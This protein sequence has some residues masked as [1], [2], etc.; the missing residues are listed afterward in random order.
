[1]AEIKFESPG[2][3]AEAIPPI[4]LQN[5][6]KQIRAAFV[7]WHDLLREGAV[8]EGKIFRLPQERVS[9]RQLR[10]DPL[11]LRLEFWVNHSEH[12]AVQINEPRSSGSENPLSGIGVGEDGR[13]FL[14]RQADLQKNKASDRIRGTEFAQRTCIPI[15]PVMVNGSPAKRQW[16]I[17]TPLDGLSA[18]AIRD[19]T[20]DFVDRCWTARSWGSAVADDQQR[21]AT[22]FASGET[23]GWYFFTPDPT[24]RAV[25]RAQGEVWQELD[26]V[27]AS[28][29]IKIQK[30]RP[31]RRYEV[32]AEILAAGGA[33]LV[34]IKT[35]ITPADIYGGIGQLMV[36][37][38]LLQGLSKHARILL[39]PGR[40]P[41]ALAGAVR[42]CGI[43]LH[44]FRIERQLQTTRVRFSKDFLSRCG[45]PS[46]AIER[47]GAS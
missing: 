35:G 34:E 25:L 2:A 20:A 39:L 32:D 4:R 38:I 8:Q 21:L 23:G 47:L 22:L 9:F 33:L 43:E 40:P 30:P 1:M 11:H 46:D 29:S 13:R 10:S 19:A 6:A 36:Y 45:I 15:A 24:P 14:L 7:A 18:G 37:P 27:L 16:H 3:P 28:Y 5:N 26:R 42:E 17:V 12:A 31:A 41:N 44:W